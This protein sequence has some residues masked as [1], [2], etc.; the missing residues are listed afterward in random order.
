MK[1]GIIF[2][3]IK[4]MKV[5]LFAV[6]VL[7]LFGLYNYYVIP[8]Q[9]APTLE[10]PAG[11]VTAIYPGTSPEDMEKLV[12]SKIEDSIAE[13][14]GYYYS[15]S[16]SKSGISNVIFELDHGVDIDK[17]WDDLREK[18][19][20]VEKDLPE[21][22]EIV[23]INTELLKT[24]GIIISMSGDKYTQEEL[25]YYGERV[26]KDL[27]KLDGISYIEIIGEQEKEIRVEVEAEKLNFYNLSLGDIVNI[28][29]AYNTEIPTGDI[30]DGDTKINVQTSGTYRDIEDIQNTIISISRD[31]GEVLRLD[32]IARVYYSLEESKHKIKHN[33][34]KAILLAGYFK[35]GRNIVNIGKRV[36]GK[37]EEIKDELPK[38]IQFNEVLYQPRDVGKSVNDF[39]RNLLL[40]M[41]LVVIVSFLSMG[42]K[43]S[44]IVSTAIPL[45]VLITFSSM[46]ILG[47]EFHQV[48]ITALIIAL[49]ML[50]DNAIVVIDSIQGWMNR[51]VD[52]LEAC[53]GGTKEVAMPVL[54]STLTTVVAFVPLAFINSAVG[55]YIISIPII[56]IISLTFSYL[57]AV[58][59]IPT[60]SYIFLDNTKNNE[61]NSSIRMFFQNMLDL[62]LKNRMKTILIA[63]SAALFVILLSS[64]L[65]LQFFPMADKDV[66]Y[67]DV[68]CEQSNNILKTEEI[69]DEVSDILSAQPEVISYTTSIGDG[70]PKFWDT[71]WPGERSLD[72]AQILVKL[73]LKKGGR[74]NLNSEF[75]DYIQGIFDKNITLGRAT[76]KELEQ[77]Q[78][79]GA[80]ITVRVSGDDIKE[81]GA[82]GQQMQDVLKEIEGT[83]NVRDDY[84]DEV[85]EFDIEIDTN[86]AGSLGITMF[87]TQN[88]VNIALEGRRAS[89]LRKD[90]EEHNIIVKSNIDSKEELENFK[91]KSTLTGEKIL[92][93]Q[94]ASVDLKAL[95]PEIKKYDRD[96][97]VTVM[98]DV[99]SGYNSVKIQNLLREKI[100]DMDFHN[101]QMTFAGEQESINNNFS[102]VGA[103][104]IFSVLAIFIVLLVQ[105][106]SFSQPF[107][108]LLV[109]P[110]S[111]IGAILGLYISRQPL[112]FTGLLGIVSLFGVVVN[113]AIVLIDCMNKERQESKSVYSSCR[114]AVEK[115]FRPIMLSTTTTVLGLVPLIFL[116]SDLFTPMAITIVSGLLI[117][118]VLTL[119]LIPVVYSIFEG[120]KEKNIKVPG[121]GS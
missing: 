62:G 5:T 1:K 104:S 53:I 57:V 49:G 68:L 47:I 51:G 25:E 36:E 43:N 101:V 77:G 9:E 61:A 97:T 11:V 116:G 92:L 24:S 2:Y 91:V 110:M 95:L 55:E 102:D 87:D 21:G 26:K 7:V 41:I 120:F 44:V 119:V 114:A 89:V 8:K 28:I 40:G 46:R 14:D 96:F 85:Y 99:K 50:V 84:L 15:Q 54:T 48:S 3:A 118:T 45:T 100:E 109:I 23:E 73:D 79:V 35:E 37:I 63:L 19:D 111:S 66:V 64:R 70:L 93:R 71:M 12:T 94:I 67:V 52:R 10:L 82:A 22:C 30:N 76:I 18:M 16:S 13:M 121:L 88:E 103:T 81:L 39:I 74:F 108:I 80:P 107:I 86:T 20:D 106:N 113:N 115:R 112:S 69:T 58:L 98:S 33:S 34:S 72:F 27:A 59:V 6:I 17:S 31:T 4:E 78:P 56:I 83:I 117:S 60:M 42:I 75:T 29:K 32:D 65:G 38:D 90:G 105:F